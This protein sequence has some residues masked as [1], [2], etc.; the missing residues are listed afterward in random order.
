MRSRLLILT[1]TVVV[2]ACDTNRVYQKNKDLDN[3]QWSI[4]DRPAFEF[5]IEDTKSAYNLYCNIRNEV[6]YP[7]ANLYFNYSIA[8]STGKELQHRLISEFLFDKKTGKPSGSSALGDIYDHQIPIEIKYTFKHPGK[9]TVAFEQFMRIDS[10]PG[11][12]AVG[13]RV[14]KADAEKN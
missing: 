3:Q 8:D 1:L 10:L 2:M 12:L 5:V 7:K 14:E 4:Q 13:L 6:S 9:Y 11:I